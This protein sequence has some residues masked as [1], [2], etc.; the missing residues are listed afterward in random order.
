VASEPSRL[1]TQAHREADAL[2]AV[3]PPP[4]RDNQVYLENLKR[5]LRRD[6]GLRLISLLLAIALWF[7]VNAGQHGSVETFTVPVVYR[8]L[9]AG[10]FIVSPRPPETIR[11]QVSGPRTLLSLIDPTRLTQRIDLGGATTGQTTLRINPEAFN[12]PRQTTVVGVVPSQITV[13]LDDLTTR[14]LPIHVTLNGLPAAGYRVAS[15]LVRPEIAT[16]RG[17]SRELARV[18]QVDTEPVNLGNAVANID[19]K[20]LL[21]PPLPNT[22]M[23]TSEAVTSIAI[24]PIMEEREF[25]LMPIQIRGT[26][27][28]FRLEPAHVNITVRG[29]QM[30]VHKLDLRGAAYVDADGMGPGTYDAPV[31]VTL[32]DS[33]ELIHQSAMKVQLRLYRQKRNARR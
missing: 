7:F 3:P 1:S 10:M 2:A 8:G 20:V 32:P 14:N 28:S 4:L 5:F 31:I 21:E 18:D 17:P 16:V 6:P 26:D 27:L 9:P 33:V 13:N 15:V 22:R 12:V 19:R 25:P 23:E 24:L 29:P 30:T 11:I